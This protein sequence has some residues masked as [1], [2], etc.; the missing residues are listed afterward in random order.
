MVVNAFKEVP[1]NFLALLGE[2]KLND[3]ERGRA[4]RVYCK[5]L[6]LCGGI[7]SARDFLQAYYVLSENSNPESDSFIAELVYKEMKSER[8]FRIQEVIH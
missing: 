6:H 2:S 4:T 7:L 8:E 1:L 3:I 5:V